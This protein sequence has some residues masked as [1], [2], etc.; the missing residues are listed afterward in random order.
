MWHNVHSQQHIYVSSSYRSNRLGLSHWDP[1]TVHR[2]SCLELYYC[3]MME[4]FWWDSSL[5][6]DDQLVSFS[7]LTLLVWSSS[8]KI[9]PKMTYNV[10]SETLS[11]YTITICSFFIH[12]WD[13]VSVLGQCVSERC[14]FRNRNIVMIVQPWTGKYCETVCVMPCLHVKQNCLK[15]FRPSLTSDWN[16]FISA[17]RN[18]PE[19]ISRL[20]QKLIAAHE[21]I[22]TCS[23][24]LKHSGWNIFIWGLHVIAWEMKRW[25]NFKNISK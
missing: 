15:L 14:L 10:S 16:N 3:N 18:L 17:C 11:L 1:Y 23:M 19:I 13:A 4:W 5:I 8:L 9:I 22:S 12:M 21:Y 7:A 6:F 2:G 20:F 25:N 24:S